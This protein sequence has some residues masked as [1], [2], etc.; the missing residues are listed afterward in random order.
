MFKN[1]RIAKPSM[2][3]SGKNDEAPRLRGD[4]PTKPQSEKRGNAPPRLRGDIPT[5]P[6]SKKRGNAPPRLRGDIPTTPQ[7][8]KRGNAPPEQK[9]SSPEMLSQTT[10]Q[11]LLR[12]HIYCLAIGSILLYALNRAVLT[13][14]FVQIPPLTL[15]LLGVGTLIFAMA[16]LFNAWTLGISCIALGIAALTINNDIELFV[17]KYPQALE[18]LYVIAGRTAYNADFAVP[19][20]CLISSVIAFATV[21]FM[22]KYFNLY[23]LTTIGVYTF[24]LVWRLAP[25]RD[26]TAVFIFIAAFCMLLIRRTSKAV[27]L[28]ALPLCIAAVLLVNHYIP[29]ESDLYTPRISL[30]TQVFTRTSDFIYELFAPT[31]FSFS[32]S[33][34]SRAGGFLGGPVIQN[35]RYVMTVQA[36]AKT[37]LSGATSDTYTGSRWLPTLQA[38]ITN[39]LT[40][41]RL[42]MLEAFNAVKDIKEPAQRRDTV[43]I[44]QGSRRTGTIFRPPRAYQVNFDEGFSD[45]EALLEITP[46]GDMQL[47]HIMRRGAGYQIDFLY[48]DT[49]DPLVEE[50]LRKANAGFY[51]LQELL[52]PDNASARIEIA[53]SAGSPTVRMLAQYADNVRAH[54]LEVPEIVPQ[55]VHDLTAELV[56]DKENDYD[57]VLAIRDY[58]LDFTYTLTPSHPPRDGCF[59]DYFLFETQEGYCTYFASA[60]AV[61]SRIAGVPSRYAEGYVLPPAQDGD[62]VTVTNRMAHAWVEVYLEGFGWHIMEAT[63]AYALLMSP[64]TFAETPRGSISPEALESL[65]G[66]LQDFELANIDL[67]T[68]FSPSRERETPASPSPRASEEISEEATKPSNILWLLSVVLF[69]STIW[70]IMAW[71]KKLK[72]RKLSY[73]ELVR[74]YFNATLSVVACLA[75]SPSLDETPAAYAERIGKRFAF[76][77]PRNDTVFLGQLAEIYYKA[78]YSPEGCTIEDVELMKTAHHEML[79]TLRQVKSK[80]HAIWLVRIR[81]V[82]SVK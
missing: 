11:G 6:Q 75:G 37:Y 9:P 38:D 31:H 45:Y 25:V 40:P 17:E 63:P 57:R 26:E 32:T 79:K 61:M 30:R 73:N 4:I 62:T 23:M 72:I 5:T 8:E 56:A 55:R 60:M 41:S 14:T 39:S 67:S 48:V 29:T 47:P 16:V 42:E 50:V 81:G 65:Q 43:T 7:S 49:Q 78:R 27:S 54:F 52:H 36:P 33:G 18:L 24:A 3:Q 44:S 82:G 51:N 34:F 10:S 19:I 21:I 64:A 35:D 68:L 20:V 66:L 22:L 59:V 28:S 80:P 76:Q 13:L 69:I 71:V 1:K 12:E 46:L 15:Y 77:T 2:G 53:A 58:L 74:L 70:G